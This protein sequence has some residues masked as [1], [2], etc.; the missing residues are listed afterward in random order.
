M[1]S[2]SNTFAATAGCR[3]DAR[4]VKTSSVSTPALW[5]LIRPLLENR[6]RPVRGQSRYAR[7]SVVGIGACPRSGERSH[8]SPN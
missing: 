7:Q 6:R 4:L 3:G 2:R 5:M 1:A 8:V